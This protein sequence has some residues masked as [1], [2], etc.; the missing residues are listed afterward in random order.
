[1]GYHDWKHT[2][3]YDR[4]GYYEGMEVWE[5]KK[6]PRLTLEIHEFDEDNQDIGKWYGFPA[7]DGRGIPSSP[8]LFQTKKEAME[9]AK[10]FRQTHR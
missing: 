2:K 8:E 10:R 1:M 5:N 9:W 4:G 3:S 7:M 6:N